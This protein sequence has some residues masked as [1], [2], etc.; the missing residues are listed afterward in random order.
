MSAG[1]LTVQDVRDW[2][3]DLPEFNT[4]IRGVAVLDKNIDSAMI[5]A[6]DYFNSSSPPISGAS[7]VI[8]QFNYR[9]A[10]LIGTVGH[11]FR[12]KAFNQAV[13]ELTYSLDGVQVADK[14][15]AEIFTKLGNQ[16]WEEYKQLVQD[17]KV[18]INISRAYGCQPSEWRIYER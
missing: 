15:K 14:N 3:E 13:N 10:L 2:I 8:E 11:L 5:H 9:Y 7:Q 12:G 6:I 1:K 16:Y 17:I 18:N 4:L